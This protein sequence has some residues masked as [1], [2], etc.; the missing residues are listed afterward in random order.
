MFNIK[1]NMSWGRTCMSEF[2]L[3]QIVGKNLLPILKSNRK[4]VL[5]YST[6]SRTF[7]QRQ[8]EARIKEINKK[9]AS[10]SSTP[11]MATVAETGAG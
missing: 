7:F 9:R 5:L 1:P 10:K 3:N 11:E 4:L 2:F 8:R 6:R